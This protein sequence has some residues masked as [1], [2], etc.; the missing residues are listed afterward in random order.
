MKLYKIYLTGAIDN[1][2]PAY[3]LAEN[4][5]EAYQNVRTWLDKKDYGFSSQRELAKV[6]LVAE[7][8]LYTKTGAILFTKDSADILK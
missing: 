3:S 6:E 7:D 4:A 2:K 8:K 1:I 5:E